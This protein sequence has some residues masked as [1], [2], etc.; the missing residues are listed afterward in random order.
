MFGACPVIS[1]DYFPANVHSASPPA[2]RGPGAEGAAA[3]QSLARAGQVPGCGHV[4]DVAKLWWKGMD[5]KRLRELVRGK[6]DVHGAQAH[7]QPKSFIE[8]F[9]ESFGRGRRAP[10]GGNAAQ[11]FRSHP[12]GAPGRQLER[13]GGARSSSKHFAR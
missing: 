7:L 13:A 3:L 9:G 11:S 10:G 4:V 12:A 6:R 2:F 1:T 5:W 8:P